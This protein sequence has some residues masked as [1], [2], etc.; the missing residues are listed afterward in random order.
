MTE[1]TH[2]T[3]PTNAEAIQPA[4]KPLF[5]ADAM[6]AQIFSDP[7]LSKWP[8]HQRDYMA[9]RTNFGGLGVDF[10][11]TIAGGLIWQMAQI[12]GLDNE[13]FARLVKLAPSNLSVLVHGRRDPKVGTLL[14]IADSAGF[15]IQF[16]IKRKPSIPRTESLI[17]EFDYF[18]DEIL[19]D[20]YLE[21][22]GQDNPSPEWS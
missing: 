22:D 13:G 14:R 7:P 4:P 2:V 19:T 16:R 1:I 17:R 5:D 15:E 18:D 3:R 8:L 12:L 21:N 9:G 20:P 10:F 6:W 11:R